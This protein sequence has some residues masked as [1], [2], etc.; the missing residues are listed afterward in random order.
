L[1]INNC[2]KTK[3]L[4][5]KSASIVLNTLLK[6]IPFSRIQSYGIIINSIV[7]NTSSS[8]RTNNF[9]TV[10]YQFLLEFLSSF[11][12]TLNKTV[13]DNVKSII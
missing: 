7:A 10:V 6:F 13:I 8:N 11:Y 1:R 12:D 4:D 3:P 5:L 9:I 2:S